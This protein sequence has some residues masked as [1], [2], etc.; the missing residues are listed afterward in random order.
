MVN[1]ARLIKHTDAQVIAAYQNTQ[2]GTQAA[3]LLGISQNSVLR[4]LSRNGIRSVGLDAYREKARLFSDEVAKEIAKKYADGAITADLVAEY[5]GS[6][7]TI[8]KAIERAG[9]QLRANPAPAIKPGE[10]DLIMRLHREGKSDMLV[11]IE[12]GRSQQ[13]VSRAIR[14]TGERI[15]G[16][17]RREAHGGWRGGRYVTGEGYV[18]VLVDLDDPMASMSD[19]VG[20][21]LEHRLVMARALGR[22]I[23]RRETVHHIDS[24]KTNNKIDNL[25]LRHGPHGKGAVPICLHCGSHNIG[26][27]PIK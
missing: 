21:V 6:F 8:K 23:T 1:R 7:Y 15:T 17:A 18:R 27:A 24:D 9:V 12:I 3:K 22:P 25:Q 20:Y 2:S 19:H 26:F 16:Q 13:F 10:L 4:V 14:K 11:S 5:G